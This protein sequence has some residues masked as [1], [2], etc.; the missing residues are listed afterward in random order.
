MAGIIK[1][2]GK[3]IKELIG[4]TPIPPRPTILERFVPPT[5]V[6]KVLTPWQEHLRA[7]DI[8]LQ[9]VT[10]ETVKKLLSETADDIFF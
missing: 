9:N 10:P 6:P 3:F 1:T 7:G 5:R 2:V 8:T 4:G